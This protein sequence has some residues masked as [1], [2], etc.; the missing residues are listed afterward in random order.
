MRYY[1]KFVMNIKHAFTVF[2]IICSAIFLFGCSSLNNLPVI[3]TITLSTSIPTEIPTNTFRPTD[4]PVQYFSPT[5]GPDIV[6]LF[7]KD[8]LLYR[9]H[10]QNWEQ[11]I[12]NVP[13]VGKAID[14]TLSPDG[15]WLA[16]ID[17]EGVKL[18]QKPFEIVKIISSSK[19]EWG[20]RL[21]FNRNGKLFAYTD[22]EGLKILDLEKHR[23]K[24]L[25]SHYL[26]PSGESSENHYYSPVQWSDDDQWLVIGLAY[27]E[28]FSYQLVH[29][30][31]KG[32]NDFTNC[33]S[34]VSWLPKSTKLLVSV[35]YSSRSSCGE[36]DG[37]YIISVGKNA[38]SEEHIFQETTPSEPSERATSYASWSPSG[39]WI[40]FVQ[41]TYPESNNPS[42]RLMLIKADG[43]QLQELVS[44]TG[45]ILS[46]IWL[47]NGKGLMYINQYD[48][49]KISRVD[50]GNHK[51]QDYKDVLPDYSEL[52]S[53]SPDGN[54]LLM[55]DD[56]RERLILLDINGGK[57]VYD[58]EVDKFIGWEQ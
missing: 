57:I 48:G 52:L 25:V 30:P 38:I 16:F 39:D 42:S 11:E 50:L 2:A 12:V 21:A 51:T 27:F 17:D 9:Y 20:Y 28:G 24:L 1:N 26:S 55:T 56:R 46:P 40:S 37:I 8:G 54:W 5:P 13:I 34:R 19:A 3:S 49:S 53:I 43:S 14:A 35:T 22:G 31:N 15:Q 33:F 45:N 23:T 32:I 10:L 36:E 44:I 4:K 18:S 41:T 7:L 6:F 29:I 58:D 47:P